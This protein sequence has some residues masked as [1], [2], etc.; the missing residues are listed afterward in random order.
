MKPSP[1]TPGRP[2][3]LPCL[4]LLVAFFATGGLTAAAIAAGEAPRPN[5]I[6]ILSDDI[7]YTDLGCYGGEIETP[8][9]DALARGGIR[10]TQFYNTA[11]CCPTRASLL[12]GLYPHQTGVGH[13]MNDRQLEG[14]RGDL[15]RRCVTIPEVLRP[16][17]YRT[18]MSGKWHVTKKIAPAGEADKHNWPL[19]RGFDRFYGTI[20]GGGSFFD[21]N[22]LTRDNTLI[23]PYADPEYQPNEYYYTDAISDHAA[24]FIRE[25]ARDH[26][27]KPFFL[28]VAY[29]APHWPM[30]AKQADIAKYKGRYD[31]G[32]D[33]IRAARLE[34]AR[35]LGV[36]DARWA[37]APQKG[38]AWADVKDR[39]FELRCMEVYAAMVDSMDQGIGRIVAEL[40]RQGQLERT[41]IL[42]MQDNGGC[43]EVMGR[44]EDASPRRADRPTLPPLAASYLQPDM[45]PKQTRDGYP[46]RQGYGVLPGGADTFIAYG[47][48]WANVS[49]TPFRE[50]KHW[51]HE[52]GIS[53][54]LIAHW[55]AGIPAARRNKLEAQ[56][57]HLIDIMATCV[58]LAGAKYPA[59][60]DGEAIHPLEGVS[61]RR[62]FAGQPLGRKEPI[63]FEHEGNRAVRDGQWKLVARGPAGAWELYDMAA[64]RT[65]L[66]NLAAQHPDRVRTMVTQWETWAKRA[67]VLPWIWTPAYGEPPAAAAKAKKKAKQ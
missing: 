12:T 35:Q 23:S 28:Y 24:K 3:A 57:G 52:G 29:T 60:H 61:L 41:L 22:T 56:P 27:G 58:E 55:P 26:R 48:A 10:F 15:N 18:Y 66:H 25:H 42:Y 50:Y 6:V 39:E 21:P 36:I 51:V 54:P 16:A 40:R 62:A 65:E 47:E 4:R 59:Q 17:G 9:L 44:R 5:V 11:R 34:R 7:G 38:G 45:I 20:H 49:N 37:M 8:N 30:H 67:H 32:Y 64:D 46:M 63:F 2:F 1:M 43:A 33:A 14:Y 19:Q 13:M 53:T 31:A